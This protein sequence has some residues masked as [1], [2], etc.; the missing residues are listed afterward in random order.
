[1]F[2]AAEKT[3]YVSLLISNC[4]CMMVTVV[5]QKS[6]QCK[7]CFGCTLFPIESPID[8]LLGYDVHSVRPV[9]RDICTVPAYRT[10]ISMDLSED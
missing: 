6:N 7:T 4:E 10:Y 1:M 5:H 9:H 2:S 3:G 8:K